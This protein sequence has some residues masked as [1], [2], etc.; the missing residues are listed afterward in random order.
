MGKIFDTFINDI[1]EEKGIEIK[2]ISYDWIKELKKGNKIHYIIGNNFDLNSA[3]S[4]LISKDKYATYALLKSKNIPI[5]EHRIIFNPN[6]RSEIYNNSFIENAKELFNENDKVI[7]K[8]NDS[9]QGKDVYCVKNCNELDEKIDMLFNDRN[10]SLSACP[11]VDIEYEYRAIYLDGEIIFIYKK[12]KPFVYG[13]GKATLKE[14]INNKSKFEEIDIDT[15]NDLD[16]NYIPN[17][18]EKIT[19]SWK[20]NLS[21]SAEPI[22]VDENDEY[23]GNIIDLAIKTGKTLDITFASIDVCLTKNK[24]ILIMEVNSNVCMSKFT[25]KISNGYEIV[26]EIYS[27]AIDKMFE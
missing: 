3:V 25:K 24:E 23:V 8:A 22:L 9:C 4:K 16:L 26:K 7:I 20:H 11:Y 15:T 17:N 13:N 19:I 18:G 12:E 14:L 10:D 2:S 6:T 27:K 21:N 1:C 5:I